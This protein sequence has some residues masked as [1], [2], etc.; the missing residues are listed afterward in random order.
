MENVVTIIAIST[1]R[2][3]DTSWNGYRVRTSPVHGDYIAQL[4]RPEYNAGRC[5]TNACGA[6]ESVSEICIELP[7]FVPCYAS[8]FQRGR[9]ADG[10]S[11]GRPDFPRANCQRHVPCK[12]ISSCYVYLRERQDAANSF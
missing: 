3:H 7:P 9:T 5:F 1:R 2:L 10:A 8:F 12:H 11:E 4:Y 6:H